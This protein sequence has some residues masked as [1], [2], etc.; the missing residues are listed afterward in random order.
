M[1]RL[2]SLLLALTLLLS[3]AGSISAS[4]TSKYNN[5]YGS[6]K[7]LSDRTVIVSVFASDAKTKWDWKEPADYENYV[8]T[9][10]MLG[11]AVDWIEENVQKYDVQT[12]LIWDFWNVPY[13][14]A[15]ASF[16]QDFQGLDKADY[17]VMNE[18]IENNLHPDFLLDHFHVESILYLFFFNSPKSGTAPSYSFPATGRPLTDYT[19]RPN[20][21][22]T[23]F[24]V[25]FTRGFQITTVPA[26]YAHEIMHC[27]GAVD[28]YSEQKQF[29]LS[30]E[31]SDW[32]RTHYPDELLMS[33][34]RGKLDAIDFDLTE[35]TAYYTGLID[36][37]DIADR[38]HLKPSDYSTIGY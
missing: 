23:E 4:A 19:N 8:H 35:I 25:I 21:R 3:Q 20:D 14:Y 15:E 37:S 7:K 31:F 30:R 24:A 16:Q 27:F 5:V 1:K 11:L 26:A 10:K 34:K 17:Y 2:L 12:D 13:L 38:W 36:H 29:N 32:Y 9:Y 33:N 6:C 18:Y 22:Y 28:L